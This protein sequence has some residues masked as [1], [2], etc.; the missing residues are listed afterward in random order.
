MDQPPLVKTAA[1]RARQPLVS[2]SWV[3][4]SIRYGLVAAF[5]LLFFGG[6]FE[7]LFLGWLYF[8]MRMVP[9]MSV[10]WPTAMLGL[11]CTIA[12]VMGLHATLKWFA[13]Q[14]TQF[15]GPM[16]QWSF[17]STCA[18]AMALFLMFAA[19][20]A[21]VGATHQFVWLLT[22]RESH[23]GDEEAM[24]QRRLPSLADAVAQ[25]RDA[26]WRTQTK[27]DLR[28]LGL[29]MHNVADTYGGL[30]PG[31]IVSADGTP[32]HGWPIMLSAYTGF[33]D[34]GKLDASV[35]WNKP[36]NDVLFRCELH[37]FVISG[38]PGPY[39][40]HDGYGLSHFAANIH[41]FPIRTIDMSNVEPRRGSGWLIDTVKSTDGLTKL[42]DITDGTSNTIMLGTVHDRFQPWGS[43]T[44]VRDPALG[45]NRSPD[46][47]GGP[48]HWHGAMFLMCDGAVRFLKEST[49]P[50][51]MQALGTPAGGESIPPDL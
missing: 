4:W 17:R 30:P 47:F 14:T 9:R 49:D 43:P 8:P 46:G 21:M 45:I 39:F 12:F 15:A 22:S 35:P 41:V 36:P 6:P 20:T 40:D 26:A 29:A 16:A 32:L 27:N 13:Q 1:I 44:N 19:G 28:Q 11:V 50:K 24:A 7:Q 18:I 51:I 33:F 5:L 23:A 25:A 48:K 31:G 3:S 37:E 10:D 42:A 2:V 38:Q 34:Y